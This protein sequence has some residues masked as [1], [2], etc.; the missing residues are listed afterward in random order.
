M[1][2]EVS[3]DVTGS[4][5]RLLQIFVSV[6]NFRSGAFLGPFRGNW[7]IDASR[8]KMCPRLSPRDEEGFEPKYIRFVY[9]NFI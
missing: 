9:V 8:L 3:A 5:I 1:I 2:L 4:V 7:G 6:G